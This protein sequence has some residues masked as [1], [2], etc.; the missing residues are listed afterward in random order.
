MKYLYDDRGSLFLCVR[1]GVC[2]GVCHAAGVTSRQRQR[3]R[4]GLYSIVEEAG[5]HR[6]FF[7]PLRV[8]VRR[9]LVR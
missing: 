2:V 4:R 3:A 1:R 5:L 9:A 6:F 7:L 8:R